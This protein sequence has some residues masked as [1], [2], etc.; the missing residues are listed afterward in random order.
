MR[1][2]PPPSRMRSRPETS[3]SPTV[4]SGS[5]S[6]MIHEIVRSSRMRMP[7]ARVMP[8]RRAS[9]CWLAGSFVTRIAMNT[10]LSMPRTISIRV[11][12]ARPRRAS[13]ERTDG[14]ANNPTRRAP[15]LAIGGASRIDSG[16][17][18]PHHDGHMYTDEWLRLNGAWLHFQDWRDD[19]GG[20]LAGTETILLLHGLTQ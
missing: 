10:M 8:S 17:G 7:R 11:S 18:A 14:I 16:R 9:S 4:T 15:A 6:P 2:R 13:K 5:V 1:N 20:G 3:R 19:H 12:V